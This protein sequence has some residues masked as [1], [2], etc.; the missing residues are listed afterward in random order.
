MRFVTS[1]SLTEAG[2]GFPRIVESSVIPSS[3]GPGMRLVA[4]EFPYTGPSG[5]ICAALAGLEVGPGSFVIADRL[6]HC[7]IQYLVE[8]GPGRPAIWLS[9]FAGPVPPV[10]VRFDMAP[11]EPS[12]SRLSAVPLILRL[13]ITRDA[14]V[15]YKDIDEE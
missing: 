14:R 4:T 6:L 2:R 1:Y 11:L 8:P 12:A 15:E 3:S 5:T 13:A 9:Q 10:A 7:R